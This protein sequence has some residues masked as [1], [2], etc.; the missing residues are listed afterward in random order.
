MMPTF[1]M[2]LQSSIWKRGVG[3]NQGLLPDDPCFELGKSS[4]WI[5]G[6]FLDHDPHGKGVGLNQGLLPDD[7]CFE[8][9][10]SSIWIMGFYLDHD[11]HLDGS[12]RVRSKSCLERGLI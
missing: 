10:K 8:L 7:P 11:P 4:I 5:M 9:G 12:G 6:F 1:W 3:L 2:N